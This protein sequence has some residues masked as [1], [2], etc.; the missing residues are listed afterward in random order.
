MCRRPSF[1]L[2]LSVLA[3]R[4][5]LAGLAALATL[6]TLAVLATLAHAVVDWKHVEMC[7]ACGAVT[8]VASHEAC[9][10]L[11]C[12]FVR[13]FVASASASLV[14]WAKE[15]SFLV[16]AWALYA[17]LT[18]V[19]PPWFTSLLFDFSLDN[20]WGDTLGSSVVV[21]SCGFHLDGSSGNML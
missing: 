6:G 12:K 16:L 9:A 5:P 14:A 7:P 18:P 8:S 1:P 10:A 2:A 17:P 4:A 15:Y 19:I 13:A 11:V 3:A 21:H 20:W